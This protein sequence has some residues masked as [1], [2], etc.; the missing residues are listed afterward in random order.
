MRDGD[1]TKRPFFAPARDAR[2]HILR[3]QAMTIL[4]EGFDAATAKRLIIESR[5]P[6]I[7]YLTDGEATCMIQLLGLK[8]G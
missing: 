4:V 8:E 5:S 6:E 1:A 2:E 7:G 3:V